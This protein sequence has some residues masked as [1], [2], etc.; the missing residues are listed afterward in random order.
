M[1]IDR[2]H[3]MFGLVITPRKEVIEYMHNDLISDFDLFHISEAIFNFFRSFKFDT[4]LVVSV[5]F[6]ISSGFC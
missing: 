3:L 1:D 4:N 6:D 2:N 5:T